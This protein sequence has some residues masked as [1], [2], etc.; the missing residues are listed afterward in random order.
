MLCYFKIW[1]KVLW[2]G[3]IVKGDIG[4]IWV[5]DVIDFV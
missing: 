3:V 2:N 5:F 4:I 1:G